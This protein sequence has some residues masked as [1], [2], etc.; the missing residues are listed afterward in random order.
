MKELICP[1]CK[2]ITGKVISENQSNNGKTQVIICDFCNGEGRF[3]YSLDINQ[4][5]KDGEKGL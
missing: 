2:G 5:I 3:K 1:K 4:M